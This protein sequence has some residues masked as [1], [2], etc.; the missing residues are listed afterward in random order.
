[1]LPIWP[2]IL[3]IGSNT[4]YHLCTKETPQDA[5]PLLS[6]TISYLLAAVF[7][8]V[9]HLGSGGAV[10]SNT[11][12]KFN[13]TAIALAIPLVSLDCGY[14]FMYR[15]GWPVSTT[16]MVCNAILA[17]ALLGLGV[18]FYKEGIQPR[19]LLGIAALLIGLFLIR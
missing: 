7:A 14:I 2:L 13:W 6:L 18:M 3:V 1:M 8:F 9:L 5:P 19:Q 16:S 12:H 15:T 17:M 11:L 10:D 4:L